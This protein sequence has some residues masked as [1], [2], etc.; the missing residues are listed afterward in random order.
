MGKNKQS[1]SGL[2]SRKKKLMR[3]IIDLNVKN[4]NA[5]DRNLSDKLDSLIAR[6]QNEVD[7]LD[8][9]IGRRTQFKLF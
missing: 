7:K 3:E 9:I 2:Q 8:D 1:I 6:K 4:A 5:A